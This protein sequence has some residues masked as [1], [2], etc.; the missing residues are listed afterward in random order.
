MSI[1]TVRWD[2]VD[3]I[4]EVPSERRNG[5]RSVRWWRREDRWRRKKEARR[6]YVHRLWDGERRDEEEEE[7]KEERVCAERIG[8]KVGDKGYGGRRNQGPNT[9]KWRWRRKRMYSPKWTAVQ[10]VFFALFQKCVSFLQDG[11]SYAVCSGLSLYEEV[12]EWLGIE[13]RRRVKVQMIPSL[14]I[15]LPKL[16]ENEANDFVSWSRLT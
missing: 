5:M 15:N 7:E 1:A 3:M 8:R 13:T 6:V 9:Q 4:W 10:N 12:S 2:D 16:R 14:S 11:L